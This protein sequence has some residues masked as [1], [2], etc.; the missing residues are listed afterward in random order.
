MPYSLTG[1]VLFFYLCEEERTIGSSP[2]GWTNAAPAQAV[3]SKFQEQ[4]LVQQVVRASAG[5][6]RFRPCVAVIVLVFLSCSAAEGTNGSIGLF[7]PLFARHAAT[8]WAL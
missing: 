6:G 7:L 5:T 1:T 4:K 3:L 2:P 8:E